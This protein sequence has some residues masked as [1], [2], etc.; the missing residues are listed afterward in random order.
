MGERGRQKNR[1]KKV[2]QTAPKKLLAYIEKTALLNDLERFIEGMA[3]YDKE[4]GAWVG[5]RD[6]RI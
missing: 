1:A 5:G 6:S 3:Q 4:E 2:V